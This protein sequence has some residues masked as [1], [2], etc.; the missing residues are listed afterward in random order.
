MNIFCFSSDPRVCGLQHCSM[1]LI[2][3]CNES[4]QLLV[5]ALSET[6][7]SGKPL[8]V[9]YFGREC[10]PLPKPTHKN[11]PMALAVRKSSVFFMYAV[12]LGL[13]LCRRYA[14]VFS[15]PGSPKRRARYEALLQ[16]LGAHGL[17]RR[18][19]EDFTDKTVV[20]E[21]LGTSVPLCMPRDA[22][23]YENGTPAVELSYRNYFN[24]YKQHL[25]RWPLEETPS[26]YTGAVLPP[27]KAELVRKRKRSDA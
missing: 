23:V 8:P 27:T 2:K 10:D 20:G 5:T 25:A 24:N 14:Q 19:T 11:H 12:R 1:H 15:V 26:W 18:S 21:F 17:R 13:A 7:F 22:I 16:K 4:I 6:E 9:G 3:L